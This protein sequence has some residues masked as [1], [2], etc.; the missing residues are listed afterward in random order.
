MFPV[1]AVQPQGSVAEHRFVEDLTFLKDLVL[2]EVE[3]AGHHRSTFGA[4]FVPF[5]KG[6]GFQHLMDGIHTVD[7]GLSLRP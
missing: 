4:R 7:T 5:L 2:V 3:P 6:G 1:G